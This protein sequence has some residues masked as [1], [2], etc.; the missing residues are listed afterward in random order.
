MYIITNF[1]PH[2]DL[3]TWEPTT[4]YGTNAH[5]AHPWAMPTKYLFTNDDVS[6]LLGPF[7]LIRP[8]YLGNY[9]TV[10]CFLW[11][12]LPAI[13]TLKQSILLSSSQSTISSSWM[14]TILICFAAKEFPFPTGH[15]DFHTPLHCCSGSMNLNP[16]I[17]TYHPPYHYGGPVDFLGE[18]LL[19]NWIFD[20]DE[21][22]KCHCLPVMYNSVRIPLPYSIFIHRT[23]VRH[24][25]LG[26][27]KKKYCLDRQWV[28][29]F[30]VEVA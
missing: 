16:F 25:P 4:V 7:W 28:L 23:V 5:P 22:W 14:W 1:H 17:C 20:T 15:E 30:H 27:V 9:S 26:C 13:H 2:T 24:V 19:E 3:P 21:H 29:L 11:G 18:A 12:L 8:T 6:T 10:S